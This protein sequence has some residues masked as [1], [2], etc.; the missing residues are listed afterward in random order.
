MNERRKLFYKSLTRWWALAAIE[1]YDWGQPDTPEMLAAEESL[2]ESKE[3]YENGEIKLSDIRP[4][5]ETWVKTH[6]KLETELNQVVDAMRTNR[7]QE[8]RA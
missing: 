6:R 3:L 8:A 2:W 7:R 1:G 5:F 4:V